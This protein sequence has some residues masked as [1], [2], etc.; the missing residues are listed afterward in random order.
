MWERAFPGSAIQLRHVRSA[1][2]IVLAGCPATD[3]VV[4]ILSEISANACQHSRSGKSGGEFLVRLRHSPGACVLGEVEDQGESW[5]GDLK[6]SA[7]DQSGLSIVL[8]L[9]SACGAE[10][11]PGERRAVWFH[12]P[13]QPDTLQKRAHG[14]QRLP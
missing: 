3:D 6:A 8:A 9:A 1:A 7:R 4:H 11:R 13:C 14:H 12:L 5:D 2:R 10:L